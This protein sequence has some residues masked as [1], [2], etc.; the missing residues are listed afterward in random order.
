MVNEN[1]KD[2]EKK[3]SGKRK[4][5]TPWYSALYPTYKSR[6]EDFKRIFKNVI[7]PEERLIVGQ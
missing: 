5:K 7:P 6:S 3:S 2:K 4:K 1:V